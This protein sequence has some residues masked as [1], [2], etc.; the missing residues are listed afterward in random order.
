MELSST[1]ESSPVCRLI[2]PLKLSTYRKF[3]FVTES[4]RHT[5]SDDLISFADCLRTF[6]L[7]S[8]ADR[9][10]FSFDNSPNKSRNKEDKSNVVAVAARGKVLW[11]ALLLYFLE[12]L[13][14]SLLTKG[15]K[16]LNLKL[17]FYDYVPSHHR[18]YLLLMAQR[19]KETIKICKSIDFHN[20]TFNKK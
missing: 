1:F 7:S 13:S 8:S 12:A 6:L 16:K 18:L 14:L 9:E 5:S 15:E 3:S 2:F 19:V 11:M 17:K 10:S 4:R 20:H